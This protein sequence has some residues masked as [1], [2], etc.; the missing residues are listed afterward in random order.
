MRR[1][2]L[3]AALMVLAAPALAAARTVMVFGD[4]LSAAYGLAS[5]QGWVSL[6]AQRLARSGASW[7][8]ANASISG[9]TTAGGLRRLAGDIAR[10]RPAIV[11][12]EL[13]ANDALRGQ[14]VAGIRSNLAQMIR[15]V[16]KARAEPVLVGLMIPPNYGI[17]YAREFRELYPAL[18]AKER[19]A[20]VPFLLAGLADKPELFQAD[21]IHPT[22]AAQARIL[23]NVWAA[24]EPLL[25]ERAS[26]GASFP[27]RAAGSQVAPPLALAEL[28][29]FDDSRRAQ[30]FGVRRGP[31]ARRPQH[32][33]ARR[34]RAR[35]RGHPLQA[36]SSFEAKRVGA[37]LVARNIARQRRGAFRRPPPHWRPLV[38]CWRG[39]GRSGSLAHVLRQ[40]G[41]DA[42]RLDGGYKAFRRQVVA[43]LE[44]LPARHRFRVICGATGSGKSRLLE[45]L[46]QAE[47]Q[48]LDL[49]ALAAHRGS[50]LGEL[51]GAPQPSQKSFETAIWTALS[52]FDPGAAGVRR[53]REPQGGQPAGTRRAHRSHARRRSSARGPG[54]RRWR[55]CSRTTPISPRPAAPSPKS[56]SAC[57]RCT[58]PGASSAG[59]S[60]WT[61]ANGSPLVAT[62]WRTTTTP[63]TGARSSA[64]TACALGHARGGHGVDRAAFLRSRARS[65]AT[66]GR[67]RERPIG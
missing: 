3:A 35:P 25:R 6:L 42:V 39:G 32:A 14:P 30:P 53:V 19:V 5:D 65:C 29:A 15:I 26:D 61:A 1:L 27:P 10:N 18:A 49:E 57:A 48:V 37:P 33:G 16:R 46:A 12:I 36:A 7:R 45:A 40:V 55:S 66:T 22:A 13:G 54:S 44:T 23:D 51:P 28:R 59:R 2:L 34:R 43:E 21:Q 41:W 58:A 64:T 67:P 52:G 60:T 8:V 4:S 31:P 11:V 47:A 24:L 20:L 17:D 62:C 63:P 50:V 56:S 9:E 38:Y